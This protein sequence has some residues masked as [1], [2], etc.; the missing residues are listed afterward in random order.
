MKSSEITERP[1]NF[2]QLVDEA[3]NDT[4]NH[5]LSTYSTSE[6]FIHNIGTL[7]KLI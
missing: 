3:I 7:F 4:L 2:Q 5:E 1:T 6:Q